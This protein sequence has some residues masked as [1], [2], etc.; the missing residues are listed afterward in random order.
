MIK[1]IN[2][3]GLDAMELDK[4]IL[5]AKDPEMDMIEDDMLKPIGLEFEYAMKGSERVHPGNAYNADN[6]CDSA[7]MIEC[8]GNSLRGRSIDHHNPGDLGYNIKPDFFLPASSLGQMLRLIIDNSSNSNDYEKLCDDL[9]ISS[10]YNEKLGNMFELTGKT[11]LG[12]YCLDD[13]KWII[14]NNNENLPDGIVPKRFVLQAAAD[15]CLRAAYNNEC[16]GVKPDDVKCL[17]IENIA[18]TTKK[19][20]FELQRLI[21][22]FEKDLLSADIF[23]IEGMNFAR[24]MTGVD[25]GFGYSA[26]YLAIKEAATFRGVPYVVKHRFNENASET[27]MLNS[28]SE[29][30]VEQFMNVYGPKVGLTKIFGNPSRGY[31]GGSIN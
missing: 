14:R 27:L 25:L 17:Q 3:F 29:D 30:L 6:K 24:D 5:G 26:E 10:F 18:K 12:F 13:G 22:G 31:A 8:G 16:P 1:Y 15:H 2:F 11:K 4:I 7:I 21:D 28:A 23:S 20:H 19:S 9:G